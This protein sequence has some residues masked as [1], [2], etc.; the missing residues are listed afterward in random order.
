[1][2][3]KE[4]DSEVCNEGE[5]EKRRGLINYVLVNEKSKNQLEDVNVYRDATGGMSDH[6]LVQAKVRLKGI[7]NRE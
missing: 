3:S 5:N 4:T 1:M 6:Y 2:V 7:L